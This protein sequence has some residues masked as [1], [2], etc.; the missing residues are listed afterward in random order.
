MNH[1]LKIT[2]VLVTLLGV[3]ACVVEPAAETDIGQQGEALEQPWT[4]AEARA[5]YEF[6]LQQGLDPCDPPPD[7]WHPFVIYDYCR[8]STQI[9]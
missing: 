9:E 3:A 4:E 1:L 8:A 5:L 2:A 6:Y 7:P